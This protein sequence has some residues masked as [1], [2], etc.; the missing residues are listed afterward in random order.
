M[1]FRLE[2]SRWRD[3]AQD[4]ILTHSPEHAPVSVNGLTWAQLL[5]LRNFLDAKL[6]ER[7][8]GRRSRTSMDSDNVSLRIVEG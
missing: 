7:E 6:G 8:R 4:L 1:K 2:D 3:G 5:D